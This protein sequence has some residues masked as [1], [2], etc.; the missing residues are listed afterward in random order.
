MK[1]RPARILP[2]LLGAL[3]FG[4]SPAAAAPSGD[5]EISFRKGGIQIGAAIGSG[6][7]FGPRRAPHYFHASFPAPRRI[8]IPAHTEV[9]HE[10]VYVPG[11][12]RR[13]WVAPSYEKRID[14]CGRRYTV[15]V[16]GYW[17]VQ[18]EPGRWE[19]IARTVHHPGRWGTR[20]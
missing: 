3:A 11:A 19:H 10:R 1:L 4:A 14:S 8:W 16:P 17:Q 6:A 9:V 12:E 20:C 13:I 18:C 15:K 2:L 5:L 7:N